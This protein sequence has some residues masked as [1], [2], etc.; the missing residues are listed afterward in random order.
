MKA[1]A[2]VDNRIL[3]ARI[4]CAKCN[5]IL[6][7]SANFCGICGAKLN[8]SVKACSI[9][10]ILYNSVLVLLSL[11]AFVLWFLSLRSMN[12][13]HMTDLGL[14]S[15]LPAPSILA[16]ILLVVSFC[17]ALHQKKLFEPILL[18]HLLLLIFMLYGVTT[19]VE[20]QP[21]FSIVYQHAG[22]TEF[23]M[24]TGTVD[25]YLDAYFNWPG[26]FILSAF[27]TRIA[28]YQDI[29]AYATW[30]PVYFN[31]FYLAPLYVI[32]TTA[33]RDKRIIWLGLCFF[34]LTNWIAQDYYSP[35]G[36]NFFLYL[37]VLAILLKWF[38]RQVSATPRQQTTIRRRSGW[39]PL[40]IRSI[41]EWLTA[42]DTL[43]TPVKPRQRRMLLASV[44]V[45]F[46]FMVFSHPLTPFFTIAAVTALVVFG[47][48]T[49]RWLP[50]LMCAMTVAWAVFMAQPYLAGHLASLLSDIGQLER[51]VTS[52]VTSRVVAGNPEH[53]L[54]GEI[55]IVMTFIIWSLACAGAILRLRQGYRDISY[56]LLAIVLFPIVLIQSYG[57]EMLL[58]IYFFTL[59]MMAFF[60]AALFYATPAR[61]LLVPTKTTFMLR[62]ERRASAGTTSLLVKVMIG[63]VSVV[64][65]V[66]FLFTRYGNEWVDYVTNAEL[67]GVRHLYSIAPKGSLLLAGWDETSWQFQDIEQYRYYVLNDDTNLSSALITQ[68]VEPI[69]QFIESSKTPNAYLIF[70]RSQKAAAQRD[71]LP[72][73]TPDRFEHALLTSGKFV[74]VYNNIDAQI[75]L[76]TGSRGRGSP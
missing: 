50:V 57:G 8:K 69:V 34:Y 38:K 1:T 20:Q 10:S 76:F 42:P 31:V 15:V 48:I 62:A 27:L 53:I 30:A 35:Q 65:L 75:F 67:A 17:V 5:A 21:R 59:P 12:L 13:Q 2:P 32:F 60:A 22:F 74:S 3:P 56:I 9:V 54:I 18:L 36:L 45:I 28:G 44:V 11:S 70:T 52:N 33:T 64:L 71:G 14:V 25:P 46:A 24:R 40:F 73:D 16:L 29:L 37:L 23:I 58:R 49:P 41:Y 26:F 7:S 51:A 55:R 72:P 4:R 68:N 47:R 61:E 63:V 43:V 19:L 6:P 66:G 39:L